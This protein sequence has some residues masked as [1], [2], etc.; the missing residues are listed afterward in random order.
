MPDAPLTRETLAELR[1]LREAAT[2]GKWET[3]GS[4]SGCTIYA[5]GGTDT[6]DGPVLVPIVTC[7]PT[8]QT[9]SEGRNWFVSGDA[10]AN[11]S[12]IA[13]VVNSLPALLAAAERGLGAG[14]GR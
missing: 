4:Y 13:Q 10:K 12:L 7:E 3:I 1:R 11:A 5:T 6:Y 9:D 2:F 14:D 8:E